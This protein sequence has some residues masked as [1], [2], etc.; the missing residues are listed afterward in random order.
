MGSSPNEVD[1][2]IYLILPAAL[3]PWGR[4][5]HQQK[6]I[7][8]MFLGV[9]GGHWVRLTT[10]TPS[11]S[12]LSRNC[13]SLDVSQPYGPPRPVTRIDLPF[14]HYTV[15]PSYHQNFGSCICLLQPWRRTQHDALKRW[16]P[17]TRLQHVLLTQT[18]TTGI[19]NVV[20]IQN[21]FKNLLAHSAPFPSNNL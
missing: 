13:G 5:S 10:S 16:Y 9:K 11:V 20:K 2:L 15:I 3:W 12:Q 18:I 17:L 4:L 19:F 7:P 21:L 6:W 8:G 1:F 14:Y